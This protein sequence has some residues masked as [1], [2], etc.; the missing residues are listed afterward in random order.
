MAI[1][2]ASMFLGKDAAEGRITQQ[3]EIAVGPTVSDAIQGTLAYTYRTGSS[4]WATIIAI[5]ILIFAAM[6]F[7]SQLRS[8]LNTIWDVSPRPGRGLWGTLRDRFLSFVAVL[9]ACLL[10]LTSLLASTGLSAVASILR[11]LKSP[12]VFTYGRH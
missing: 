4:V 10:L 5:V 11:P 12:Q 3:I 9:G 2:I 7:F 1:A 6:G 8:D